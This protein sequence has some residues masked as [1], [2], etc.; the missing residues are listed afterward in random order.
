MSSKRENLLELVVVPGLVLGYCAAFYISAKGLPNLAFAYPRFL[1]LAILGFTALLLL[2]E[3]VRFLRGGSVVQG[4]SMAPRDVTFT[5][6]LLVAFALVLVATWTSRIVGL[7]L[8][9]LALMLVLFIF[10]C[11]KHLAFLTGLS[12]VISALFYAVFVLAFDLP[13]NRF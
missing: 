3:G 4:E 1:I 11:R 8:A 6:D 10:L 13:L 12:V 9:N 5:G 7:S 2:V